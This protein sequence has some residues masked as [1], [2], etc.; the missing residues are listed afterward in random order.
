MSMSRD[1]LLPKKFQQVHPKY[2]TPGFA[3]IVTGIFIGIGAMLIRSG[4]VTD[5]TSIGTLFAFV[6][7]SAGVL[8]LPRIKPEPGKFSLPYINGQ[9]IIPILFG[10]LIYLFLDRLEEIGAL[11]G[12]GDWQSISLVQYLFLVYVLLG[13]L[14]S[15]LTF[16]RRYSLIPIMGVLSCMYLMIEIPA[17]SWVW[18]L[19]WMG[20]G[21][22][23]YFLYGYRHSRLAQAGS[24]I[25]Q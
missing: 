17:I 9:W 19:F 6:L 16:I 8:F 18:F 15:I 20:G 22:L 13:V 2:Q 7:V 4:L 21:L 5:L 10:L 1:G 23:I 11:L 3:T 14:L 12:H 24:E 25:G